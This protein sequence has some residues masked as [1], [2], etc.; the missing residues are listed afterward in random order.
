MDNFNYLFKVLLI[1][2]SNVGKTSILT[3]F[4]DN[5][6]NDNY[7]STIGVD[8]KIKTI[9]YNNNKVKLQLWD[10]AGQERFRTITNAYYRGAHAII[11][12]YDISNLESYQNIDYWIQ[13]IKRFN[14]DDIYILLV[15]NKSDLRNNQDI[16][17]ISF[18][19]I[20]QL[21]QNIN[22]DY[23][24]T[25]AKLNVNIDYIFDNIINK[26]IIKFPEKNMQKKNIVEGDFIDNFKIK[27]STYNLNQPNSKESCC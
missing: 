3:R 11:I 13:E 9:D 15:G 25:S 16:E 27:K 12:I 4:A 26:L 8:F 19:T 18:Q 7:L 6:Y 21:I 24:E 10:T 1:G 23:I 22:I 5:E 2:D 17:L 20:N 14:K